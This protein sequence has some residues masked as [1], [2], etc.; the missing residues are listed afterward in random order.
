MIE[1][2][3]TDP[4]LTIALSPRD[5]QWFA[6]TLGVISA[7]LNK[8]STDD[9]IEGNFA[10]LATLLHYD[11]SSQEANALALRVRALLPA[12]GPL[13]FIDAPFMVRGT[14]MVQ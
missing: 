13:E 9:I 1:H 5:L 3:P 8:S 6:A 4:P 7:M 14:D 2:T 11:Y 10:A 12:D